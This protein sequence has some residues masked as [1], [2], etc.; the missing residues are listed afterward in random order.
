MFPSEKKFPAKH[1]SGLEKAGWPTRQNIRHNFQNFWNCLLKIQKRRNN[2]TFYQK[3]FW[4][5]EKQF[6]MQVYFSQNKNSFSL[7]I[8]LWTRRMQ[9]WQTCPNSSSNSQKNVSCSSKFR[10]KDGF[11]EE[12]FCPEIIPLDSRL[13]FQ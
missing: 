10:E 9:V 6:F 7:Q 4:T 13:Q 1:P 12:T 2:Q 8:C 5:N 11:F 3:F